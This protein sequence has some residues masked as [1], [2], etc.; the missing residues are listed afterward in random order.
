MIS[1]LVYGT[2][3]RKDNGYQACPGDYACKFE[4]HP[5]SIDINA[6]DEDGNPDPQN[7]NNP[8]EDTADMFL[9]WVYNSFDYTEQA[10]GAG[11][12]RYNWWNDR[13]EGWVNTLQ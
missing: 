10:K 11:T 4:E 3:I 7:P 6:K 5:T 2:Y 12:A 13:M 9:N 1:G 8:N